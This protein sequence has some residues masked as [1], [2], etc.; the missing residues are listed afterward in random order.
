M[1][2]E[3]PLAGHQIGDLLVVERRRT[4]DRAR[5]FTLRNRHLHAGI[6]ADGRRTVKVRGRDRRRQTFVGDGPVERFCR[7]VEGRVEHAVALAHARRHFTGGFEIGLERDGVGEG[8]AGGK[9]TQCE[10]KLQRTKR[11]HGS[12][13]F[14]VTQRTRP[15]AMAARVRVGT[16]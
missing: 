3:V 5:Q 16:C 10:S 13:P 2:V 7:R 11:F 12:S 14:V 9:D 1:H 6:L 8:G 4:L 15:F